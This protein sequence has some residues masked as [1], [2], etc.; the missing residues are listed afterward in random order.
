[1]LFR[2]QREQ[3]FQQRSIKAEVFCGWFEVKW[4]NV[5][6]RDISRLLEFKYWIKNLNLSKRTN[7]TQ[8]HHRA[9]NITKVVPVQLFSPKKSC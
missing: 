3:H 4:G 5:I 2:F 7:T 6:V 1:M 9:H 8:N